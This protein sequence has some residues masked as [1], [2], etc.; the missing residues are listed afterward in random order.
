MA[1]RPNGCGL[2]RPAPGGRRAR[3][4]PAGSWPR[5]RGCDGVGWRRAAK[6]GGMQ[7]LA[8][9]SRRS[10]CYI[11]GRS[12]AMI[13]FRGEA[14][15]GRPRPLRPSCPV[16]GRNSR[17]RRTAGVGRVPPLRSGPGFARRR[18]R[19][20]CCQRRRAPGAPR[21]ARAP[22]LPV[23]ARRCL[24]PSGANPSRE[25]KRSVRRPLPAVYRAIPNDAA[26]PGI[27]PDCRGPL[28]KRLGEDGSRRVIG[29]SRDTAFS[30][31]SADSV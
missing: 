1:E 30:D 22:P 31:D 18:Q 20:D 5:G 16:A 8:K 2:R 11:D 3:R 14:G 10:K 15:E 13:S 6:A 21:A 29:V 19:Y 9:N 24:G 17:R 27:L 7:T 25:R 4:R 23:R 12:T 26:R 28:G